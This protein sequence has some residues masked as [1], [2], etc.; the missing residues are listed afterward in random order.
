[1]KRLLALCL[2]AAAIAGAGSVVVLGRAAPS[3]AS[4]RAAL[5]ACVLSEPEGNANTAPSPEA[6]DCMARL[7]KDMI[8]DVS[9][10]RLEH[11]QR[12]TA[13]TTRSALKYGC[14]DA[15]H[16]AG[17][18]AMLKVGWRQAAN[19]V[20]S[21][22][23]CSSGLLHGVF[24]GL[25]EVELTEQDWVD[26]GRWCAEESSGIADCGDS[27]GHLSWKKLRNTEAAILRCLY[28]DS[29]KADSNL[30]RRTDCAD[31]VLMSR[32]LP[33]VGY[34]QEPLTDEM[35][36]RFC[37]MLLAVPNDS[38][39]DLIL[40]CHAGIGYIIAMTSKLSA[41]QYDDLVSSQGGTAA[42][43]DDLLAQAVSDTIRRCDLITTPEGPMNCR[44]R[45]FPMIGWRASSLGV[46]YQKLCSMLSDPEER[47]FCISTN[48]RQLKYS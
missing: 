40:G 41:D 27:F 38:D 2:V 3:Y 43:P 12:A 13:E 28:I 18:S 23:A 1:M 34:Q 47:D 6:L 19:Q 30:S 21:F 20:E 36:P 22:S 32:F 15:A 16:S 46:D 26:F 29:D 44:N 10:T 37:D 5:E 7:I 14:H 9:G 33:G 31:G 39:G 48:R 35:I 42:A 25:A 8:L 24:D 17:E 4:D 11:L 45:M